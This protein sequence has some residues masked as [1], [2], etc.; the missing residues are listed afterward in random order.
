MRRFLP[1]SRPQPL[2]PRRGTIGRRCEVDGRDVRVPAT[3]STSCAGPFEVADDVNTDPH[4]GAGDAL[5]VAPRD[6]CMRL[7][8]AQAL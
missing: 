7:S 8:D 3:R 5:R 1:G 4:A 2:I 6:A